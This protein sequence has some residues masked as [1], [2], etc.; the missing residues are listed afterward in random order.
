MD[1][2][3]YVNEFGEIV[4]IQ[5]Q[6]TEYKENDEE[7]LMHEYSLLSYEIHHLTRPTHD[8]KKIARYE[9]LKKILKID[10]DASGRAFNKARENIRMMAIAK[11][12]NNTVLQDA[13]KKKKMEQ[14]KNSGK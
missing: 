3:F 11:K 7:K 8:P 10:E 14:E 2:G 6:N 13:L 9:E 12:Q 5:N 1:K 4:R